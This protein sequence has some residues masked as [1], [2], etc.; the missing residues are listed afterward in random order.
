MMSVEKTREVMLKYLHS[1]HTDVSMMAEGVTLTNMA[2]GEETHGPQAVLRM[3]NYF[4]RIAFEAGFEATNTIFT[5]NKAVLE[6]HF[7]GV[8]A[9]EFAGIP[10]TGR[11]VRVPMCRVYDLQNGM[12]IA[13]R[14]YFELPVLMAQLS[15]SPNAVQ[16][17]G[18]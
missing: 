11:E 4:Y 3:L 10:A 17:G 1:D 5:E 12:I 18:N 7:R 14:I 6:G 8:H 13:G 15:T 9:G 16:S 2:T